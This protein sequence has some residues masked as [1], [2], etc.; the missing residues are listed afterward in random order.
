MIWKKIKIETVSAM[1]DPLIAMLSDFG[2]TGFEIEDPNDFNSFLEERP[3][4]WDYLDE[5]LDEL[6]EG[7]SFVSFYLSDTIEGA[8]TLAAVKSY[9]TTL[10][11]EFGSLK[12]SFDEVA[13]EDFQNNYK[14]YF[15]TFKLGEKLVIKPSWEDYKK[16]DGEVVI[17]I[18]PELS[19][20]TGDHHTT[21]LVLKELE[22]RVQD[23]MRFLDIGCGSGI[24]AMAA[25]LLGA[26]SAI[27]IDID[28]VSIKTSNEN[29]KRIDKSNCFEGIVGNIL[30]DEN[31][32]EKIGTGFPLIA[33]NII[34]DVIIVLAPT[35]YKLLGENGVVITSGIID[36]RCDE[37][38]SALEASGLTIESVQKQGGWCAVVASRR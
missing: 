11:D 4:H 25:L 3:I 8:E 12:L 32:I 13:D 18:D 22:K 21:Q 27:G 20:G 24:L 35:L 30:E 7:E 1:I 5:T 26:K 16:Q 6:R 36:E 29:I 37:T 19:F 31:V 38:V 33:A 15:K 2:I 23:D 28:P 14:K 10:S 9:L 17:E 34:A